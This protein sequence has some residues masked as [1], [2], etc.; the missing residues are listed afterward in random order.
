[1]FK[2]NKIHF[3][4]LKRKREEESG[5]QLVAYASFIIDDVLWVGSV[6]IIRDS[7]E[8]FGYKLKYPTRVASY[9]AIRKCFVPIS[10]EAE[11]ILTET[12]IKEFILQYDKLRRRKE[13]F[14]E[15][16]KNGKNA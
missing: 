7:K 11:N 1:M 2:I 8:P 15:W 4:L 13:N 12:I 3:N 6:G 5:P 14:A 16:L 10:F 9:G